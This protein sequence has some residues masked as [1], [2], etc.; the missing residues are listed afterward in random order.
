MIVSSLTNLLR[1]CDDGDAVVVEDG[2]ARSRDRE[3]AGVFLTRVFVFG[4]GYEQRPLVAGGIAWS[5]VRC[6]DR[7]RTGR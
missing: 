6:V 5:G 7:S 1:L 3:P 2:S 4:D